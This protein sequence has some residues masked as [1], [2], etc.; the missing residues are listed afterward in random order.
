MDS[1]HSCE[2]CVRDRASAKSADAP[3]RKHLSADELWSWDVGTM[4]RDERARVERH[5]ARCAECKHAIDALADAEAAIHE[6]EAPPSLADDVAAE[7]A[8]FVVRVRRDAKRV[9]LVV[10]PRGDATLKSAMLTGA[11]KA[12]RTGR[13][14]ELGIAASAARSGLVLVV[15]VDGQRVELK[16]DLARR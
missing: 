12:R 16:L 10:E 14:L 4:S 2:E 1:S 8:A 7:H 13:G 11:A 3:P 9:R 15:D 6:G 5:I